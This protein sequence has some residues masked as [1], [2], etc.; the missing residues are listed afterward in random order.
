MI[1]CALE[2][3]LQTRSSENKALYS[4]EIGLWNISLIHIVDLLSISANLGN[5]GEPELDGLH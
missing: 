2:V 4:R 3:F 5:R 1:G